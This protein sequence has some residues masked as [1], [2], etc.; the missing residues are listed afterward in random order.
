M[1]HPML[2]E[3][4][5]AAIPAAA[6]AVGV[7]PGRATSLMEVKKGCG[8]GTGGFAAAPSSVW[9]V[10]PSLIGVATTFLG[11]GAGGCKVGPTP[12]SVEQCT[13]AEKLGHEAALQKP[14]HCHFLSRIAAALDNSIC[15][16]AV[17]T[18]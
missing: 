13:A 9:G 11:T 10:P 2:C 4:S 17:L 5:S 14:E 8:R 15:Y 1:I 18:M 3:D 6:S 7:L 12:S 16:R